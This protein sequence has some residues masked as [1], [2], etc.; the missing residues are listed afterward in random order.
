VLSVSAVIDKGMITISEAE[1]S[2]TLS[3]RDRDTGL[4]RQKRV[5]LVT[6]VKAE[7]PAEDA[8]RTSHLISEGLGSETDPAGFEKEEVPRRS[9]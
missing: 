5:S 2:A 3:R 1:R 8:G 9:I 6:E 4:C 7:R